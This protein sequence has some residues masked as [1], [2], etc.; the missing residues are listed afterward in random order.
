MNTKRRRIIGPLLLGAFS[1]L[2]SCTHREPVAHSQPSRAATLQSK[3][4]PL[5]RAAEPEPQHLEPQ[6]VAVGEQVS[7]DITGNDAGLPSENTEQPS[8]T[9]D[10]VYVPTPQP[11]VEKMLELV[12][13]KKTDV[14]YD[15]GC[16]DGRIVITAAKKYGTRAYGFDIDPERVQEARENVR[17]NQLEHLVTIEQKDIFTLD[18]SKAD[19]VTLYLLPRLNVRLIP[20]L[21]KLKPGARI[22]SHDFDMQGVT[23]LRRVSMRP[24]GS[25]RE[26]DI[27]LWKAPIRVDSNGWAAFDQ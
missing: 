22:V 25:T 23:P 4:V 27:Y 16:G 7:A 2:A 10:V 13:P 1:L 8:R 6:E 24:E 14:V 20:Q 18:L 11:V 21:K 26:H 3:T 19:I 17:Q 5:A 9:P 15:L 12:K